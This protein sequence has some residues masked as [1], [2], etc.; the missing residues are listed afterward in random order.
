MC[1]YRVVRIIGAGFAAALVAALPLAASAHEHREVADGQYEL[2]VG[3]L[4]EPAFVGLKNG[5]EL[6]VAKLDPA[7]T[8]AADG[9]GGETPVDGLTG[10]LQA[11]VVYGAETMDLELEP[12]FGEPGSYESVFFPMAE[13]A[14]QFRV[15]GEI[16]GNAVDETFES[17]PETFSEVQAVEPLQFPKGEARTTETVAA[18]SIGGLGGGSDDGGPGGPGGGLLAGVTGLAGVAFWLSR[19]RGV[20]ATPARA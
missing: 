7:A 16:E 6:R 17:G 12:T 2:T 4:E 20:V 10:S 11:Q 18:A 3:F 14:Y 1:P 5:L 13:G 8:P 15:F 9:E 19:R